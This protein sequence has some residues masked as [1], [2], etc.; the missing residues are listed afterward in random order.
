M[1]GPITRLVEAVLRPILNLAFELMARI[2]LA[3]L[4]AL[5]GP[6]RTEPDDDAPVDGGPPA[7]PDRSDSGAP[8]PPPEG[9]G[10]EEPHR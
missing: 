8:K 5:F 9:D 3:P 7:L 10:G 1:A 4:R 6:A 2:A